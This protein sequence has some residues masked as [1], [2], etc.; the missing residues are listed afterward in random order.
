[1]ISYQTQ[2][3]GELCKC[4]C[5][6]DALD[7]QPRFLQTSK[8]KCSAKIFVDYIVAKLSVL[9]ASV[10]SGCASG[11]AIKTTLKSLE[12]VAHDKSWAWHQH[13]TK[14]EIFHFKDFS[15]KCDQSRRKLFMVSCYQGFWCYW[16]SKKQKQFGLK[17]F[18]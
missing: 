4:Y 15:S 9:D 13:S 16:L 10:G 11:F 5:M 12:F 3:L 14:N 8:M 2:W 7:A 17:I 18:G 6:Q 1:M